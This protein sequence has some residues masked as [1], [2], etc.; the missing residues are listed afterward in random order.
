MTQIY[1]IKLEYDVNPFQMRNLMAALPI[2]KQN[3]MNRF[4]HT[5]DAVRTLTADI[6]SRLLIC[7]KLNIKN[8]DIQLMTNKYGKPLLQGNHGLHFNNSHSGQWVLSALSDSSIGIDVEIISEIDIDIADHCFSEQECLDLYA[9]K[10]V[11]R[12]DYFFNLWTLKESYIKAA[13]LGLSLPL[14]SFT[15]RIDNDVIL[16]DTQNEFNNC[17]FK[18]YSIDSA[19]KVSVCS[20]QDR[21]PERVV[22]INFNE[23]YEQFIGYL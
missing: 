17:Y 12:T 16:L 10:D 7:N 9:Q 3:R 15:I 11:T 2:E 19:Y 4:I 22:L 18:Q 21:F 8:S 5:A 6:L 23:M 13:G 1:G 20:Q 14:S